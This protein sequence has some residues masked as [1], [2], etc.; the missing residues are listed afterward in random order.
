MTHRYDDPELGMDWILPGQLS[1][2]PCPLP[3]E[4][5]RLAAL[6]VKL[7][8][9][10]NDHPPPTSAV[11]ATGMLHLKLPFPDGTAPDVPLLEQF[12]AAVTASL[13]RGDPVAVHCDAG[14]GRTGTMIAAYLVSTG[15]T[16]RAAIDLVRARHPGSIQT[17]EQEDTVANWWRKLHGWKTAQWR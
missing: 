8:V 16:A 9:S 15:M 3:P 4:I 14:L 11:E 1:A 12:V 7:L 13:G 10:L 6:G 2:L 17:G 5:P